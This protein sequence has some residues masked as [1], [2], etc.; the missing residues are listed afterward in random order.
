[1]KTIILSALAHCLALATLSAESP[2]SASPPRLAGIVSVADRPCVVLELTG[3]R[4]PLAKFLVLAEGQGDEGVQVERIGPDKGSVELVWEGAGS[5]TVRLNNVTNLPVPGIVLEDAGI[6]AV[7]QLFARFTNRTLLR[8]PSLPATAFNLR[9]SARDP[10]YAARVLAQALVAENLSIIPDGEKFL[11]IVPNSKAAVIKPH[12]P[13]AKASTGTGSKAQKATLGSA[14]AEP[15]VMP[16]GLID[17]RS[18]DVNQV[19]DVYAM[20]LGRKLDSSERPLAGRT[21]SLTT[22]TPITKEEGLYAIETLLNWSGIK[23]V[24]VGEGK[25]KAVRTQDD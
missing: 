10:A 14:T 8:W 6:S 3:R 24:S 12:A 7:L 1:M 4:H 9:A 18:A 22:Q 13:S 11:M 15:E 5:T 2:Q 17:F 20:M 19:L 21:I 25:L 23:L 16:P